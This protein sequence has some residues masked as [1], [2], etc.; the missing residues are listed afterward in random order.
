M[1]SGDWESLIR[2]SA[3]SKLMGCDRKV[4]AGEGTDVERGGS[5]E[6]IEVPQ[7]GN[8]AGMRAEVRASSIWQKAA[9]R[10]NETGKWQIKPQ[11]IASGASQ[12]GER[13]RWYKPWPIEGWRVQECGEGAFEMCM[14]SWAHLNLRDMCLYLCKLGVHLYNCK[15]NELPWSSVCTHLL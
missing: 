5:D 4:K 13:G 9:N 11:L 1:D 2:C 6:L 15:P 3:L 12:C 7:Q 8:T 10:M 14:K